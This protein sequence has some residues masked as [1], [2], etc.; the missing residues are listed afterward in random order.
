[1]LAALTKGGLNAATKSLAL[2]Y[3]KRG[4][5]VNAVSPGI[6]KTPL[7]APETHE[8]LAG[9]RAG[10]C[11]WFRIRRKDPS[12]WSL[13]MTKIYPKCRHDADQDQAELLRQQSDVYQRLGIELIALAPKHWRSAVLELTA[14]GNGVVHEIRSDEGHPEPVDPSTEL[15]VHIHALERFLAL[16]RRSWKNVKF[17]IRMRPDE[18][19]SFGADYQFAGKPR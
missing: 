4:V 10:P 8:W 13:P 16:Y 15:L 5:R 19:W 12:I 18:S 14:D 9:L 17:R 1:V 3:A 6:I 11:R 7:H 2:E